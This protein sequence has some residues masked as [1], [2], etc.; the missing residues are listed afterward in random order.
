M[1]LLYRALVWWSSCEVLLMVTSVISNF[2]AWENLFLCWLIYQPHPCG[3]SDACLQKPQWRCKVILSRKELLSSPLPAIPALKIEISLWCMLNA[4]C[5]CIKCRMLKMSSC[6]NVE[7]RHRG[8]F[9]FHK[10]LSAIAAQSVLT[11]EGLSWKVSD[12]DPNTD[13][14]PNQIRNAK[15]PL[16]CIRGALALLV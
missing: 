3:L 11:V 1:D 13:V 14:G 9:T 10:H 12:K 16:N 5:I 8:Q 2:Q 4:L 15:N 7:V 6:L